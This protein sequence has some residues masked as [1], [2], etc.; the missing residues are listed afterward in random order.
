[1]AGITR[2]RI[3]WLIPGVIWISA[4]ASTDELFAEYDDHFCPV[5]ETLVDTRTVEKEVFRDRLVIKEVAAN[6]KLMPWDPAVYFDTDSAEL[7]TV[8]R[9]ALRSNLEFLRQFPRFKVSIRGFTDQHAADEYN[10]E[11][12]IKRITNV[13][14]FYQLNGLGGE[15][16][17]G[18]AHG[19]SMSV[20]DNFS[21]VQDDISRRVEMILLD[22][23]GRPV[24]RQQPVVMGPA[25]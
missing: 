18:R 15:R 12:S 20:T 4:C 22:T 14:R 25:E 13:R 10:R 6:S 23:S 8:A 3:W 2:W 21:P 24:V 16:M 19:E 17:F 11:L 9:Q 7:S 5:P 1:M